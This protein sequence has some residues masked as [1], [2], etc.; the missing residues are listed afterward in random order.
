LKR[1]FERNVRQVTNRLRYETYA[2]K[3]DEIIFDNLDKEV[4]DAIN[5]LNNA[6]D[7]VESSMRKYGFS[8]EEIEVFVLKKNKD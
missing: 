7:K 8:K 4:V 6:I 1:D 2:S 5:K 3:T